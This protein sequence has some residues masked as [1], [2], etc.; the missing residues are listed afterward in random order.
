MSIKENKEGKIS[1]KSLNTLNNVTN[2]FEVGQG[3]DMPGVKGTWWAAYNA[4]TE[5]LSHNKGRNADNRYESLWFGQA[6][7]TNKKALDVAISLAN[8]A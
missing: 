3:N 1:T 2:L 6:A 4:A 5:Y 7:N 8:A